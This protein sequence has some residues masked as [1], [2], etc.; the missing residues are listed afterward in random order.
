MPSKQLF[1]VLL[2]AS[3][4]NAFEENPWSKVK[5]AVQVMAPGSQEPFHSYGLAKNSDEEPQRPNSLTALG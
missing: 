5:Y 4:A 1:S 2:L 3:V